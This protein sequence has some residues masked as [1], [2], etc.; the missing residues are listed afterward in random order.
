M[1]QR[2]LLAFAAVLLTLAAL[3]APGRAQQPDFQTEH[4][5]ACAS[6]ELS[7]CAVVGLIYETGAGGVQDPGRAI[8]L[9]ERACARE[10][11]VACLRL[12][13][14]GQA[15]VALPEDPFVRVGR[16]ADA[17]TAAPI[18]NALIELPYLDRRWVADPWGRV[19]LGRLPRGVHR[20]VVRR[21]GYDEIVG[22]LPV[23]WD[24]EF[25][26][27][28][29]EELVE[30]DATVGRVYG[31]V[32][33]A[34]TGAPMPNV[35]VTLLAPNP[36]RTIT[37]PDGRFSFAAI[38]PGSAEVRL[39]HLGYHERRQDI[40]VEA[41]RTVEVYA[42]LTTRPF[43]LEP[44]EVT[45]GSAYLERN[46]FFRRARM[47]A[48]YQMTRRDV[49]FIDPMVLSELVTRI[50]GVTVERTRQGTN[51]VS[52]RELARDRPGACRLRPYLDGMPM[53]DWDIDLVH[54]QDVEGIEVHQGLAAPIEY[55]N[56]TDPDGTHPCGVLLIWTTRNGT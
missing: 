6:G 19:D 7:S 41:G 44:I 27:F 36:M 28:M 22:E 40:R 54:P 11:E 43:E 21:A 49:Q 30:E 51:L 35:E 31:Q 20:I 14:L 38:T 12:D 34:A 9:Y 2:T 4:A 29:Y 15:P 5:D 56:L 23:P 50:P 13:Q 26:L 32:T 53:M 10:V 18:A 24:S 52:R 25:V 46:G 42:S 16:V 48:G 37:N 39:S 17:E 8:E 33:D 3:A 55:R 45:V 1:L 47:G